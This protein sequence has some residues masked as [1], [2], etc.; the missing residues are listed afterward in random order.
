LT[1][2]PAVPLNF[3]VS[4]F[5][6]VIGTNANDSVI[7]NTADNSISGGAGDDTIVGGDGND[8]IQ[9]GVGVD[10][11]TG[12]TGSDRFVQLNG[13]SASSQNGIG[14]LNLVTDV[15]EAG[16]FIN[17]GQPIDLITDFDSATDK[18][19][20]TFAGAADLIGQNGTALTVGSGN[21]FLQGTYSVN[22]FT[23]SATGADILFLNATGL[24]LT[25][26]ADIGNT[27]IVLQGAAA[28]GF[29]AGFNII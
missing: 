20:A 26:P 3:S 12:G 7:G 19:D 10:L 1:V 22:T 23:A 16:S 25:N 21:F 5:E 8:T 11:L 17:F 27:S 6:N 14:G 18:L 13:D 4:S 29:N 15:V 28:T 9:G 2:T 24:D